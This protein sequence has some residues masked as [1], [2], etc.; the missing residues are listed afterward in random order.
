MPAPS[1]SPGDRAA[2][3]LANLPAAAAVIGPAAA[4]P[5][6]GAADC[7]IDLKLLQWRALQAMAASPA[8]RAHLAA[9]PAE[10]H[11]DL[12]A[13]T[14]QDG[15]ARGLAA[16]LEEAIALAPTTPERTL[17]AGAPMVTGKDL[18]KRKD[19]LV[20]S[21]SARVRFTRKEGVLFVDRGDALHST[22]C[23]R[24]EARADHGTL[25][26]FAGADDERP[27][28]FSAQFL[29]AVRYIDAG[30]AQ[31]LT[32]AG[33][34]GRGPIGWDCEATFTGFADEPWV[35]LQLAIDNR[36]CGWRLRARFL[37]LPAAA[38]THECTPVG[39]TVTNDNGGFVA[40]TLVR[41]VDRLTVG[42]GEV[43]TPGGA[44]RGRIVHA[45][46]LGGHG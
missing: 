30:D 35:R 23:L 17:P 33:R 7:R 38:I 42:N 4:W 5:G 18:R 1:T 45:F 27:R 40:F 20:K 19:L 24:F 36:L 25:D 43:A 10:R 31:Q 34:V 28:L 16:R 13:G 11:P 21:G 44:C 9:W 37:G 12:W 46:R 39:E 8:S 6:A 29:P 14:V 2:A 41:A 26:G 22:N 32:I 3:T 15:V